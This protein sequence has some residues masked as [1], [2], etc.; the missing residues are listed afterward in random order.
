MT[1]TMETYKI[2]QYISCQKKK[3]LLCMKTRCPFNFYQKKNVAMNCP[4]IQTGRV[5]RKTSTVSL[6][7]RTSS[8]ISTKLVKYSMVKESTFLLAFAG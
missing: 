4:I 3:A 1:K 2:Q 7:N 8:G 5:S 6:P